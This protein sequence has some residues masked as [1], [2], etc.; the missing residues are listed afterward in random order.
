[1]TSCDLASRR[2]N[3]S[4]AKSTE[5]A[6]PEDIGGRIALIGIKIKAIRSLRLDGRVDG[7]VTLEMYSELEPGMM[8]RRARPFMRV[9]DKNFLC[10]SD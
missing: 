8:S 3:S 5:A 6:K 1:M 7:R 2:A 9:A 4:V 10:F